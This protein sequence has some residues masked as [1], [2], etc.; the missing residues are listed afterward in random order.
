VPLCLDLEINLKP[1]AK[2]LEPIYDPAQY[3]AGVPFDLLARL[4]AQNA[5]VWVDEHT[6]EHWPGGKGF[7]LVLR[8]AEVVHVLK[9]PR[10]FSSALGATQMMDPAT[11]ADLDYVRKMM[12]N[13]DPPEHTRLRRLLMNSFTSRAIAKIETAIRGHARAIFDRV[14][15]GQSEGE[16]DF[17]RDI[18]AD[19]P[20]LTLA[21]ILGMPQEDRYLMYDWANRVIGFQ[22]PEYKFSNAFDQERGSAIAHEAMRL[23]PQADEHGDMPNPRTR[24]GMP[25]LYRYAHLLAEEKRRR[26]ADDV[27]S[28][29]LA[30]VDEEGGQVSI[31]EFENMFWLFAVAGNETL[32]NGIPGGMLALLEHPQAFARLR[33]KPELL[34]LAV[35]EMLR[36]WTPVLVFRR[37]A[38]EDTELGDRRIRA[39]DKVVVSFVSANRDERVFDDPDDFVIDRTPNPHL[40]FG[41][42][43]HFCL[44]AHLARVQMQ[45]IFGEL[46]ER[47]GHI[48]A[49]GEVSYLRSNFQRGMKVFPVKWRKA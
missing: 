16:C 20:L 24:D 42:G 12:L 25:D 43:P 41:H 21:D 4:R 49:A 8:H 13:M 19:M 40:A 28:I 7:W 35:D 6:L 47:L 1:D 29:L 15:D 38:A 37:T 10:L 31:E 30:Q 34:P 26:P 14:L 46:L 18:A 27:M 2:S 23:R 36:W 5:V 32:R 48:E 39:G 33:A 17:S 11:G 45:A 9:K 44:G 3:D 22:D